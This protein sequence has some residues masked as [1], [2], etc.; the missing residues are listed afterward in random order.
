[1]IQE[2]DFNKVAKYG[3]KFVLVSHCFTGQKGITC[4]SCE[5]ELIVRKGDVKQH[6]FC[7][8][9]GSECIEFSGYTGAG[10]ETKDHYEAKIKIACRFNKS[11]NMTITK[12][13]CLRCDK[14]E[15]LHNLSNYKK[16]GYFAVIE[17]SYIDKTGVKRKADVAIIDNSGNIHMIIEIYKSHATPEQNREGCEWVELSAGSVNRNI[18]DRFTCVRIPQV[19][20]DRCSHIIE[21]EQQ[22]I[23]RLY[24]YRNEPDRL[25]DEK[26]GYLF[27]LK[28]TKWLRR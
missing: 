27:F 28:K 17:Q 11:Q 8:K 24:E 10:G 2:I 23:K 19:S 26:M 18:D 6:H 20:C 9:K 1:M 16:N 12:K 3:E 22:Y 14:T 5:G 21:E 15:E 25:I 13:I 7:H 4:L